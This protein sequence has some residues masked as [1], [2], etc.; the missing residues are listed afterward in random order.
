MKT[1][2]KKGIAF[3]F[4]VVNAGQRNTSL[5]PQLIAVSTEGN[6][7]ITPAVSKVLGIAHGENIMFISNTS[8]IDRAIAEK[9]EGIVAFCE[10]AGLELGSIEAATA[11]HAEFDQWAIA[12]G[13]QEYDP[14]GNVKTGTERLTKNDRLKFVASKFD[15]MLEGALADA[16]EEVIEALSRD[17]VTKEEQMDILADFVTPREIPKLKGSK[18]ANPSGATGAGTSLT[19]TDSN[20][21]KQ[22]KED[23][24]ETATEV[25][26][27]YDIDIDDV[28]DITLDNG[29]E[30][31][32]VKALV[33]GDYTD[34]EPSRAAASTED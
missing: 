5:E 15:E 18:A 23:L 28:Q 3:G 33:L 14:K 30:N 4:S 26:R 13:V 34:K 25:N 24:G 19:F 22:L 9:N 12:K 21:W 2:S 20:V 1:T 10:E 16:S 27:V 8:E 17:G 6:F 11:I 31:I 7:R 32:T 29:F